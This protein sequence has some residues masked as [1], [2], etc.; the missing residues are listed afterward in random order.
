MQEYRNFIGGR[1]VSSRNKKTFANTN[2]ADREKILGYFSKSTAEDVKDAC[3]AAAKAFA[4]WKSSTLTTR[5]KILRRTIDILEKRKDEIARI[6]TKEQGRSLK[7]SVAEVE[8]SMDIIDFYSG[9]ARRHGGQV[10]PSEREKTLAFT[11]RMPLGVFSIITPWNFPLLVPVWKIVPAIVYGNTVVFKP[12]TSTPHTGLVFCEILKEAGLPDG[13]VNYITGFGAEIGNELISNFHIKGVSFTGSTETGFRIYQRAAGN[14]KFIRL[15]LEL[16]GKNPM[17]VLK[18]ADL[19][20]SLNDVFTASFTNCGQRCTATSRIILE[21][22]ISDEFTVEFVKRTKGLKVGNGL[23][24]GVQVGAIADKK[25]YDTIIKYLQIGKDEGAE[26]LCGG[27]ALTEGEYANGNFIEPTIFGNVKQDMRI[28]REEIFGPV[29]CLI[30]AD[31]FEEA[32]E[33][34]NNVDYGLSASIY[35]NDQKKAHHFLENIESGMAHV[36]SPSVSNESNM[37]FGGIKNSGFGPRENGETNIDFFT[38]QKSMYIRY[39]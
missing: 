21:K 2:P 27:R 23:K 36:N 3:D 13:V 17:V 39:L 24:D 25:Q 14:K 22:E 8:R 1:Y 9:E 20:L 4:S 35:T 6:L 28:A 10:M 5:Y 26:I 38:E 12:A 7:E 19:K 32:M 29:V 16:G 37:P 18:D 31:N 34:A 11:R 33:V 15:Q 30:I